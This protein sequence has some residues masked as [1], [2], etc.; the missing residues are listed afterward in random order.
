M[1]GFYEELLREIKL[2][3]PSP[4]ENHESKQAM[5]PYLL[6]K[7]E[8]ILHTTICLKVMLTVWD[9]RIVILG[10]YIPMGDSVTSAVL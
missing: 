6:T 5:A 7:P 2:Y 10:H 3:P 1:I 4:V 8:K 9:E